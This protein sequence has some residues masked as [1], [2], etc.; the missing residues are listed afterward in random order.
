MMTV[1]EAC[2]GK[3]LKSQFTSCTNHCGM[4]L[5]VCTSYCVHDLIIYQSSRYWP[6]IY[7]FS[8]LPALILWLHVL[9]SFSTVLVV[10]EGN[11]NGLIWHLRQYCAFVRRWS[12]IWDIQCLQ[13]TLHYWFLLIRMR[14]QVNKGYQD[15]IWVPQALCPIHHCQGWVVEFLTWWGNKSN[16]SKKEER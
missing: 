12:F 8:T 7:S 1:L 3:N 15:H 6:Q 16:M 5:K 11:E 9:L 2:S 13:S 10:T 14:L 4:L